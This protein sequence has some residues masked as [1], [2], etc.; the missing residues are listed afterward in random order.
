MHGLMTSVLESDTFLLITHCSTSTTLSLLSGPL[1]PP[2][3]VSRAF[4]PCFPADGAWTVPLLVPCLQQ[5]ARGPLPPRRRHGTVPPP[6]PAAGARAAASPP[7][8]GPPAPLPPRCRREFRLLPCLRGTPVHRIH[9]RG[10]HVR[11]VGLHSA[12]LLL[13][14]DKPVNRGKRR[15]TAGEEDLLRRFGRFS[16]LPEW[17]LPTSPSVP[18]VAAG[19]TC[20]TDGWYAPFPGFSKS[21]TLSDLHK[22]RQFSLICTL[23]E[24]PNFR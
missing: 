1:S 7:P 13:L 18:A 6:P 19:E 2:R 20:P 9:G 15:G 14:S 12:G 22:V 17:P 16:S 24:I 3:A 5:P 10:H 4:L 8:R 11:V 23:N 21:P